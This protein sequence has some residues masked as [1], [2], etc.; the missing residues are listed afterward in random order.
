[1]QHE[2]S[3]QKIALSSLQAEHDKLLAAY[4]RSQ[5]RASALE[6]KHNVSD[7]E[8]ISLTE[9]KL[10]L[11]AQVIE[12]E[13]DVEDLTKSRD[14]CR[15]SAVQEATQ[16]IEMLKKA[17]QLESMAAEERKDWNSLKGRLEKR[18]AAL[19][20]GSG[21][22]SPTESGPSSTD[23]SK[24]AP[25]PPNAEQ[26]SAKARQSLGNEESTHTISQSDV[27][28]ETIQLLKSEVRRLHSRCA[29]LETALYSVKSES[30]TMESGIEAIGAAR[31]TMF[32]RASTVLGGGLES[33]ERRAPPT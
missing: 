31:R 29:E 25:L 30:R 13:K 17:S 1:L 18:I 15:T 6:K 24:S 16:Y 33:P 2:V 10:R 3:V 4:L 26:S 28:R 8:I 27:Q 7:A 20:S 14:E 12:L 32:E 5:T 11:Q 19:E 9:E 22:K 23:V 21:Q